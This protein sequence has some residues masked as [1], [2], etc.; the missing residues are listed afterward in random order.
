MD[1]S[2]RASIMSGRLNIMAHTWTV[3]SYSARVTVAFI[4]RLIIIVF[5]FTLHCLWRHC[6]ADD[7]SGLLSPA[8]TLS[9]GQGPLWAVETLQSLEHC[10]M[11][12]SLPVDLRLLSQSAYLLSAMSENR[13][14]ICDFAPTRSL[15]S[16]ISGRRGRPPPIIFAWIVRP[17]NALQTCR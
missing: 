17:M 5:A 9:P 15:W 4:E 2:L 6:Q 13:S 11:W 3:N 1:G 7:I 8:A 12:K 14:K 16:K 10:K